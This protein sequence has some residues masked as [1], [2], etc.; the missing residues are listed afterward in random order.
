MATAE[1]VKAVIVGALLFTFCVFMIHFSYNIE[2]YATAIAYR[3]FSFEID[4]S[5]FGTRTNNPNIINQI[6]RLLAGF[7]RPNA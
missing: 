7:G 1:P 4:V 6:M 3:Y 5:A 2:K